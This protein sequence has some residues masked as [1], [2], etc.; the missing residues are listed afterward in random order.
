[1]PMG[2]MRSAWVT[3]TC[4]ALCATFGCGWIGGDT[5]SDPPLQDGALPQRAHVMVRVSGEVLLEGRPVPI[6]VLSRILPEVAAAGGELWYHRSVA[7][8]GEPS[9]DALA[10]ERAVFEA[11]AVAGVAVR[12]FADPA[13]HQPHPG[14]AR[15][16]PR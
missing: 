4:L 9:V 6:T 8:D 10:T 13:F 12:T 15:V 7:V 11:A 14:P 5:S 3:A 1:M 16:P 2:P